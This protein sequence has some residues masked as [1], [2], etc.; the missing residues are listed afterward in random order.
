MHILMV[1]PR[2]QGSFW[3]MDA[4]LDLLGKTSHSPPLG[5]LSMAAV[6]PQRWDYQLV[7]GR[8]RAP[9]ARQWDWCDA[10]LVSG[11]DA[12][13]SGILAAIAEGR[14]RGKQ[15]VVGGPWA[16]H[17]APEAL[18]AGADIV[19]QGEGEPVAAA[20]ADCLERRQSGQVLAADAWA[21]LRKSATPRYDL[22]EME[23]YLEMSVQFSRGCPFEC[24]FCDVTVLFGRE[25]RTKDPA[26]LIC[27]LQRLYDL[28]WRGDV[29]VVDDNLIGRPPRTMALLKE[30]VSW[31]ER[32]GYPFVFSTQASINLAS[33]PQL[34]ELM[35]RAGFH[36]VFIG[37]ESPDRTS[38]QQ[39]RKAP[40]LA[41]DLDEACR[42][43]TRAGL[44]IMA[45]FIIGFDHEEAGAGA[46]IRDF[47]KRNHIAEVSI[48][49]LEAEPGTALWKRLEAEDRHP[50]ALHQRPPETPCGL[51][52]FEPTRP[53]EQIVEEYLDLLETLFE[54]EAYVERVYHQFR[55]MRPLPYPPP[56]EL[57]SLSELRAVAVVLMRQGVLSPSR[58]TFWKYL[59]R[60]LRRF[61]DRFDRYLASI[62]FFEHFRRYVETV[63][64]G[65]RAELRERRR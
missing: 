61:P 49:M 9:T 33:H 38:L 12:Q 42:V 36:R 50:I 60:G 46:R 5:L 14:R 24:E 30:L 19:V 7:D 13:H 52:N 10:L 26:Q 35:V 51:T 15:V 29:Y 40:N 6:L 43:I 59:L 22:L 2:Y 17:H 31:Q 3:S 4:I 65:L 53:L 11:I 18:E 57:P 21:D 34:L 63:S 41:M 1:Y 56:S 45:G 28:G 27:E 32:R 39:A 37:I 47:A 54:P 58:L 44:L 20:L 62:V 8:I 48:N 55:R 16:S 23:A 64:V 25:S